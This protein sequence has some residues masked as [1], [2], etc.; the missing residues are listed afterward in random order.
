MLSEETAR[1]KYPVEAVSVMERVVLEA[2]KYERD[3]NPL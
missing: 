2:E 3:V 1:G